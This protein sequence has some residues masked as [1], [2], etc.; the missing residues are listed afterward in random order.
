M[1][2]F[3]VSTSNLCFKSEAS[4]NR[5][6]ELEDELLQNSKEISSLQNQIK[7]LK[8]GIKD[9]VQ[10]KQKAK[11]TAEQLQKQVVVVKNVLSLFVSLLLVLFWCY[12]FLFSFN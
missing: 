1:L 7:D 6:E 8:D 4:R 5:C 12:A 10:E 9:I 3:T 2:Q 11:E